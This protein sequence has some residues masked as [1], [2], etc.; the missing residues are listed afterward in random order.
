MTETLTVDDLVF[1][2]RRSRRR[3]SM[4]I[5]VDRR[6]ELVLSGPPGCDLRR[7]ETFVR[8]KK[9]WIYG[10]LALKQTFQQALAGKEFVSGEGFS[11]LGRNYRLLLVD[12]QSVPLKLAGGRLRLLRSEATRGRA[13]LVRW[14]C[15]RAE[16]W[17]CPRMAALAAR[18]G[19]TPRGLRVADLGHRWGSCGRDGTVNLHWATILLPPSAIEYVVI[20][21][22]VHLL[23]RHHTPEFWLRV[24]RAMPD[25]ERRRAWLAERGGGMAAL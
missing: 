14:Y 20:H 3:R 21:E 7:L 10:K 1:E 8:D 19:V 16:A 12:S 5:T 6:G 25:Y 23:E 13:H 11:Y 15:R 22:L 2:V 17:F 4:Q 18:V 9:G 24:E